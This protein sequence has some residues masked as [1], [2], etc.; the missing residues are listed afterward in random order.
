MRD[1]LVP[2][3]ENKPM[4][5]Q[6]NVVLPPGTVVLDAD[7]LLSQDV[8]KSNSWAAAMAQV[9]AQDG[10]VNENVTKADTERAHQ[11]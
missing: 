2:I 10:L 9:Q 1:D 3:P 5:E 6:V 8:R 4:P 7:C 11:R